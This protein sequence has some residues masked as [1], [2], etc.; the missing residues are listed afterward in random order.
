M[1]QNSQQNLGNGSSE[2]SVIGHLKV[3]QWPTKEVR[4]VCFPF[5]FWKS[6][7]STTNKQY[8]YC[9]YIDWNL[10][11]H[12]YI[13]NIYVLRWTQGNLLFDSRSWYLALASSTGSW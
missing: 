6:G 7:R 11:T 8:I 2:G 1:L 4:Q 9:I 12:I 3:K 10:E 5:C 13:S